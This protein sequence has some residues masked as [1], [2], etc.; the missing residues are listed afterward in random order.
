MSSFEW[1]FNRE[2]SKGQEGKKGR[3]FMVTGVTTLSAVF[4][5]E[6]T[7]LAR[8]VD[9]LDSKRRTICRGF[10]TGEG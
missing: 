8:I 4:V 9:V 2:P 5:V 1:G 6:N 3:A 10:R 7:A